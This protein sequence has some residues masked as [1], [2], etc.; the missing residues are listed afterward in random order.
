MS[1]AADGRREREVEDFFN[2]EILGATPPDQAEAPFPTAPRPS[3]SP[4][5]RFAR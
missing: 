2:E 1:E 3:R 5:K 4:S